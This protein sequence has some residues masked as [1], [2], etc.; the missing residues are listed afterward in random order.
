MNTLSQLPC[1]FLIF[2]VGGFTTIINDVFRSKNGIL[3][4]LWKLYNITQLSFMLFLLSEKITSLV[5]QLKVRDALLEC[6]FWSN[7]HIISSFD[8]NQ[9]NF[10]FYIFLTISA[11]HYA[12]WWK[13]CHL[14]KTFVAVNSFLMVFTNWTVRMK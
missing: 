2:V 9:T 13:W 10:Q 8:S 3:V 12:R 4:W 11:F 6:G 14:A 7:F 1:W 5:Q